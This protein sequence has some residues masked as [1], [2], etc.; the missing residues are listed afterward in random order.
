MCVYT[1]VF[2][3]AYPCVCIF[4]H[5]PPRPHSTSQK[6][7]SFLHCPNPLDLPLNLA[8]SC[9]SVYLSALLTVPQGLG[10]K[11]LGYL[12]SDSVGPLTFSFIPGGL[13]WVICVFISV[14]ELATSL[15][16]ESREPWSMRGP[17][18]VST[19]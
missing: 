5:S 16:I 12:T 9:L 1:S 14:L 10:D 19:K 7:L 15:K 13:V 3:C 18:S 4:S 2:V 17:R 6:A 11:A 8:L